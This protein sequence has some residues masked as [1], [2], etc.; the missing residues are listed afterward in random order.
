MVKNLPANTRDTGDEGSIPGLGRSPEGG[1]DN[2]VLESP[3]DRGAWQ[4]TIHGIAELTRLSTEHSTILSNKHIQTL[5]ILRTHTHKHPYLCI[6]FFFHQEI[7]IFRKS[8]S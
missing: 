8:K 2:S 3:M 5:N 6:H 1:N 7:Y 4:A